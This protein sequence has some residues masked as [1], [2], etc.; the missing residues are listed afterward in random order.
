[1]NEL[2]VLQISLSTA[3]DEANYFTGSPIPSVVPNL[4]RSLPAGMYRVIDG[5]LCRILPGVSPRFSPSQ[6]VAAEH[7]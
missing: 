6:A 3:D 1:V 5:Q 7:P 2:T 4:A